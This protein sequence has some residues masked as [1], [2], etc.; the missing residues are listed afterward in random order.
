MQE[1]NFQKF[2]NE[3]ALFK[4]SNLDISNCS[5]EDGESPLKHSQNINLIHSNFK[6][7]YPIWYSK[8]ISL[9]ECTLFEMARAGVWYSSEILFENCMILAPKIFRRS[10]NITLK[11]TNLINASETLWNCDEISLQNVVAKGEYFAMNSKNMTVE[12]L[13]LYGN[14]S[15]DGCENLV[16]TN[17]KII[18]KDA[19]WNCKNV[20]VKDS[21]IS[22][23][24][25]GWNSENLSFENCVIESIQA[26]C[27]IKNL[28]L[29]N[30]QTPS[31]TLAFEYS[32]VDAQIDGEISS[33]LNPISGTIKAKNIGE[34]IM[35]ELSKVK[36]I[37]G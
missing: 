2:S 32:S 3:R 26:L 8:N 35:D 17:S 34:C 14:Y 25:I 6:Y 33:I 28:K 29:I 9:T 36:I 13:S 7:K 27:Y 1:L 4:V 21:Y 18:S 30:C 24:Y 22:G 19:F 15:F 23:E 20:I 37:K 31:T 5:F 11:N 12:N 16:I 10:K